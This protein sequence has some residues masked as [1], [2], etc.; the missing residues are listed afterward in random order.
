VLNHAH[1]RT[2]LL[3]LR[4]QYALMMRCECAWPSTKTADRFSSPFFQVA[5]AGIVTA[6]AWLPASMLIK[7]RFSPEARICLFEQAHRPSSYKLLSSLACSK[8]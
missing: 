2:L 6:P 7:V 8:E 3:I 5:W 4:I 1:S